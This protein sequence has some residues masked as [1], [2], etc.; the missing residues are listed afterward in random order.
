MV[1]VAKHI[2]SLTT[3]NASLIFKR[4][5]PFSR[6]TSS[7]LVA[8]LFSRCNMF[9]QKTCCGFCHGIKMSEISGGR[10]RTLIHVGRVGSGGVVVVVMGSGPW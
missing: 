5:N 8:Q 10:L 3:P 1:N 6:S 7:Q 9:P 4:N 2:A